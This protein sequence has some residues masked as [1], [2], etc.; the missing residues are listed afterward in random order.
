MS[1]PQGNAIGH[2]F[3]DGYYTR[4]MAAKMVGRSIDTLKRWHDEGVYVATRQVAYGE[5]LVWA[6]SDEDIA[7]LKKIAADYKPGRKPKLERKAM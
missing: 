3:P 6:Y 4:G 1:E 2:S 7:E 5:L